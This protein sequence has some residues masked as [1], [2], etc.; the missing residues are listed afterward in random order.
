MSLAEIEGHFALIDR[1]GEAEKV[2]SKMGPAKL[3]IFGSRTAG[4]PVMLA[5]P[6]IAIDG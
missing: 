3:L 2:G 5:A 1:I 6:S 4:T